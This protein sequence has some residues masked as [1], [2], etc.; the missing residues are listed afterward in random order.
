MENKIDAWNE[1]ISPGGLL[2]V[3]A[4]PGPASLAGLGLARQFIEV[5]HDQAC[6]QPLCKIRQA[7]TLKT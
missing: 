6:H 1:Q 5:R 4:P 2:S 3:Q 7:G